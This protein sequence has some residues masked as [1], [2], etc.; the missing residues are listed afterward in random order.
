MHNCLVV[1]KF[2]FCVLF[3]RLIMSD[4]EIIKKINKLFDTIE[5][6]CYENDTDISIFLD[7][8]FKRLE[9][10]VLDG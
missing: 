7:V 4:S 9:M 3:K 10:D 6:Y 1:T 5:V 2:Y 8:I